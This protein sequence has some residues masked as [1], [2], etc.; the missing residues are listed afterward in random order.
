MRNGE[1]PI[2]KNYVFSR[3]EYEKVLELFS[4]IQKEIYSAQ[5]LPHKARLKLIEKLEQMI[6]NF[7]IN[8][9]NLDLFWSFIAMTEIAFK[10]YERTRIPES[11]KEL[12]NTIWLIQCREEGRPLNSTPPITF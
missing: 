4:F 9:D 7:E 8:L 3:T 5:N 6:L 1:S 11:L 12:T 2:R 10:I